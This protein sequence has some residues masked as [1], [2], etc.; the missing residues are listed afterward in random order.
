MDKREKFDNVISQ[1]SCDSSIKQIESLICQLGLF[2][3]KR[4]G[5]DDRPSYYGARYTSYLN[6][7][8]DTGLLQSPLELARLCK[9]LSKFRIRTFLN[10]GTHNGW[11]ITFLVKYL[12]LFSPNLHCISLDPR[13]HIEITQLPGTNIDFLNVTSDQFR[14]TSFDLVFIDGNHHFDW[15]KRDFLN[16]GQ[17][18]AHCVFHDI[19]SENCPDVG[20]FY[21]QVKSQYRH[22]EFLH[23]PEH[24]R[25]LGIGVLHR[26]AML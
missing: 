11:T 15:V 18:A 9:Y 14:G 25:A 16:V 10:I 6:L 23:P 4:S 26:I 24:C 12:Q 3:F 8:D 1:L 2:H 13:Q 22:I 20:Y 21:E 5:N 17:F 7:D 19:N